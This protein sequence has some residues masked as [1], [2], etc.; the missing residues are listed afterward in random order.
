MK[1]FLA[2]F[3]IVISLSVSALEQGPQTFRDLLR[4]PFNSGAMV[5]QELE[6]LN[7]YF[8]S[9]KKHQAYFNSIYIIITDGILKKIESKEFENSYCIEK[10]LVSFSNLYRQAL[11]Q[12]NFGDQNKTPLPWRMAFKANDFKKNKAT[13]QLVLGMNA[14]IVHDLAITLDLVARENPSCAL[15]K[16]K[17][18]YFE[19]N[20]FFHQ[21]IS[22]LNL[23]L[24]RVYYLV[25]NNSDKELR[26]SMNLLAVKKMIVLMRAKAW[27]FANDLNQLNDPVQYQKYLRH[28]EDQSYQNTLAIFKL[29]F[30]FPSHGL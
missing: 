6:N 3:L 11:F 26:R 14:H 2:Y 21:K 30:L 28:I 8:L 1:L 17:K 29:E 23:E 5:E 22:E 27:D 24:E 13:V 25:G 4:S 15:S 20:K 12:Y 9:E 19:L 10:M 18:D 16:V 7:S